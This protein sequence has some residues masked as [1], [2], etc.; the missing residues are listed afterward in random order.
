MGKYKRRNEWM[1]ENHHCQEI[2][3]YWGERIFHAKFIKKLHKSVCMAAEISNAK[4]GQRRR[5]LDK[6][7]WAGWM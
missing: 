6:P 4:R 7:E 2:Y 5:D 3:A 1:N